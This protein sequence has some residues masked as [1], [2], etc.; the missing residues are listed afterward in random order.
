MS[1]SPKPSFIRAITDNKEV[2]DLAFFVGDN[3]ATLIVV[4]KCT[5]NSKADLW[6][7]TDSSIV[8]IKFG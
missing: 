7:D 8:K 5:F 4:K 1:Y 6:N 2:E 3:R